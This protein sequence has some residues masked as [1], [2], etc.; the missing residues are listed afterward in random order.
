M[1]P[2]GK[3]A[4]VI[5]AIA[6]SVFTT[7][8]YSQTASI[9]EMAELQAKYE[10][11]V[12]LE[13]VRPHE[14]AVADLNAKYAA[15][16]ERAQESAQKAGNLD[17]AFA[18]KEEKRAVSSGKLMTQLDDAKAPFS[19]KSMRATYQG[20]LT[21]LE[22]E[23]DKNLLPLKDAYARSLEALTVTLT[24]SGRLEEAMAV[25]KMRE[26]L[27]ASKGGAGL[28]ASDP[29][30]KAFTN[31]LGMKFVNVPGTKVLFCIHETR[32]QDYEAYV[33]EN[34]DADV[35]W[36]NQMTSGIPL[37][38]KND[39]PV[40]NVNLED[41]EKFCSWLS[42]KEG[43]RYRLPTDREWS[44]AVGI[45]NEETTTPTTTPQMLNQKIQDA[46]P[47]GGDFPPQTKDLGGN[48]AD[49]TTLEKIPKRPVISNYTD[50]FATTAPVMSLKPNKMGLFDMGGNVWELVSDPYSSE[51]PE[52]VMRGGCWHDHERLFLLSSCRVHHKSGT[53]HNDTGF[54]CV[55]ESDS[56]K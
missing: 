53:R 48:Y 10:A 8:A 9:P 32:R 50:G 3:S 27:L 29:S 56:G 7:C 40:L 44:V 20:A 52:N 11:K 42:K 28:P 1:L 24:K 31:S 26:D 51:T 23:R 36:K 39:H 5:M 38:D 2:M 37:G 47:W 55:V 22:V 33:A 13:V 15:A 54:R 21:R 14:L 18:I 16:L 30:G 4:A 34:P 17:A 45:G 49:S 43:K 12:G 46:F 35:S 25:K 6:A 41:A 19:L